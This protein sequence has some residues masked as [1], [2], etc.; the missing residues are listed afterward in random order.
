MLGV[1]DGPSVN[2]IVGDAIVVGDNVGVEVFSGVAVEVVV[3]DRVGVELGG[4]VPVTVMVGVS[5]IVLVAVRVGVE[6]GSAD[7]VSV[8]GW[9]SVSVGVGAGGGSSD[10]RAV[11]SAALTTP[12]PLTSPR[13]Q[14][15][16]APKMM[17]ATAARSPVSTWPSQLASPN[18]RT[19]AC[20][21]VLRA[22][23]RTTARTH[24]KE[25]PPPVTA[26]HRPWKPK[27]MTRSPPPM[28]LR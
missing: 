7:G 13:L 9:V 12:S 22:K 28:G 10:S 6:E 3:A 20:A 2:V 19:W 25:T 27:P 4:K 24:R 21:T 26:C 14:E 17:A 23:R 8:G 5:L 11:R 1:G 16:S 18:G 15:S